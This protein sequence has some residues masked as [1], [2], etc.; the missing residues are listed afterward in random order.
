M[1]LSSDGTRAIVAWEYYRVTEGTM[2]QTASATITGGSA[3]WGA[4]T[5]FVETGPPA[6][7]ADLEFSGDGQTAAITYVTRAYDPDK[8][9][10]VLTATAAILASWR[11]PPASRSNSVA[12]T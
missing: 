1:R 9:F 5:T 11:L 6:L 3:T 4:T 8:D 7:L 12:V 2:V 10:R